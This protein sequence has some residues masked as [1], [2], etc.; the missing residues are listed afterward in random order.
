MAREPL[1]RRQ[2]R[3]RLIEQRLAVG[4]E[5]DAVR[6][7]VDQP[8]PGLVLEPADVLADR[9]LDHAQAAAAPLKLPVSATATK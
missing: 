5:R 3:A 4:G 2:H 8:P 1:A 6:V 9:R 7:T